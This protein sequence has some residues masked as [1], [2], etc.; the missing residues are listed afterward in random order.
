MNNDL[1]AFLRA[2]GSRGFAW[3]ICDCCLWA[4]D[5]V[6]AV[7][8]VDPAHGLR[9]TYR[10]RR[11]AD[12]I[13]QSFGGMVGFVDAHLAPVGIAR[14]A[15][16][17]PGDLAVV[18]TEF[19]DALGIVT[20]IGVAVKRRRPSAGFVVSSYSIQAAWRVA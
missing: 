19:G 1:P 18:S 4:A 12:R 8:G 20:G 5:W 2:S 13:V 10:T 9:G 6:C 3:G 15:D 16:P 11:G 14:T 7:K 17:L